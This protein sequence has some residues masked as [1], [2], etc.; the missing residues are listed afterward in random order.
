MLD[1]DGGDSDDI[2]RLSSVLWLRLWLRAVV[3]LVFVDEVLSLGLHDMV[4]VH[5]T[6]WTSIAQGRSDY[7]FQRE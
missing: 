4:W 1:G 3:W 6:A 2:D 5:D 7:G